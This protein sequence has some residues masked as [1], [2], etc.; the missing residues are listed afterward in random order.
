MCLAGGVLWERRRGCGESQNWHIGAV[1]LTVRYIHFGNHL[2]TQIVSHLVWQHRYLCVLD[3][4][5]ARYALLKGTV[6]FQFPILWC[7]FLHSLSPI[8]VP[9]PCGYQGMQPLWQC[10]LPRPPA[11]FPD[12][13][14][15]F[16]KHTPPAPSR[17]DRDA[18][19]VSAQVF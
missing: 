18:S 16:L 4:P 7:H 17:G 11:Q 2:T 12:R 3:S 6:Y 13:I 10:H 5:C 15:Q 1:F 8:A 14:L 19:D 9:T